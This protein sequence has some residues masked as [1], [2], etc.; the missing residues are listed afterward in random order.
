[1]PRTSTKK[2]SKSTGNTAP[3]RRPRSRGRPAEKPPPPRI[4]ATPEM[5]AQ[6]FFQTVP[7]QFEESEYT[8]KTCGHLVE[9]PDVLF[10]DGDCFLC[11]SE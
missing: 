3:S 10:E 7:D 4:D 11:H 1:M 8:C 5:I 9:Y 6:A 2:A